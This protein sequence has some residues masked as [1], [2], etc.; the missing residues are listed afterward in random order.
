MFCFQVLFSITLYL[1]N[2]T[3]Y[4]PMATEVPLEIT[5]MQTVSTKG[6]GYCLSL[7]KE[8][9]DVLKPQKGEYFRL[10]IERIPTKKLD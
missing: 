10:T 8:L 1:N 2:F 7:P 9:Y 5:F 4:S 3:H 6:S